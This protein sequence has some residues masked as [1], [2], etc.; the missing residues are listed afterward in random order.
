MYIKIPPNVTP[1]SYIYCDAFTDPWALSEATCL[2]T[3]T[4]QCN[5]EWA[6]V[7]I[8]ASDRDVVMLTSSL[9]LVVARSSLFRR[10]MFVSISYGPM[11]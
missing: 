9:N 10:S 4:V 6:C 11:N 3:V 7:S 2:T 5:A 1:V 8:T